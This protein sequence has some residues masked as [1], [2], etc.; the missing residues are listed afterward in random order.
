MNNTIAYQVTLPY[1][2]FGIEVSGGVVV[3]AAPVGKWMV[4]KSIV[5]VGE[6]IARKHGVLQRVGVSGEKLC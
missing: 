4:G 6:W 3:G 5:F 2:C 1:A